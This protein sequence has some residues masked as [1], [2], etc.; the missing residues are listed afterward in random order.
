M[1]SHR[2]QTAHRQQRS[3]TGYGAVTARPPRQPHAPHGPIA[4]ILTFTFLLIF[5]FTLPLPSSAAEVTAPARNWV[6]PVF[7]PEGFREAI[8]RG[9]EARARDDHT[10]EV[11]DLNL[12]FFSGDAANRVD[13]VILSPAATFLPDQKI[14]RGE[15]FVRFIRDDL[16]ASGIRWVYNHADKKISLDGNVRVTFRA[17]I[18][19]LLR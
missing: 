14:A 8:G 7:T 10:F 18:D 13:T 5:T 6:L 1:T 9:S 11:V 15:K 12:T 3:R 17:E 16:E 19:D 4:P 2:K